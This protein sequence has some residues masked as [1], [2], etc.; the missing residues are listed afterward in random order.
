[1]GVRSD[2]STAQPT[3]STVQVFIGAKTLQ[4]G[5]EHTPNGELNWT[6]Q[7]GNPGRQWAE[8]KSRDRKQ[9]WLVGPVE[10][11]KG[12]CVIGLSWEEQVS[13]MRTVIKHVVWGGWEASL[14]ERFGR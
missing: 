1:M 3:T 12:G 10:L 13:L 14:V 5:G 6:V 9:V 7:R 11:V 8:T 4:T 2:P